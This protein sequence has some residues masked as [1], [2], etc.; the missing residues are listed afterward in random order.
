[1]ELRVRRCH[2]VVADGDSAPQVGIV[3][4]SN[5]HIVP[6]LLNRRVTN[7]PLD[8][9]FRCPEPAVVRLHVAAHVNFTRI[10]WTYINRT[11]SGFDLQIDSASH[12]QRP[13]E[14]AVG[15]GECDG[16]SCHQGREDGCPLRRFTKDVHEFLLLGLKNNR[17]GTEMFVPCPTPGSQPGL[18]INYC[19]MTWSSLF[20]P[21]RTSVFAPFEIPIVIAT[22]RIPSLA[23]GSGTWTDAFRSLSYR[24]E[25]SGICRTSLC[26][27]S[28]I[29]AFAVISAFN[30]PPGLSMET[31]TSNVVTLSF[32]TP[33]GEILVTTPL[34]VLSLKDSTLIRAGCPRYTL[35]MSLSSTFPF[36]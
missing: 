15:V 18:L 26:S 32:S 22:L 35:P 4:M 27:S 14:T 1:M 33:I 19:R 29:S 23:L 11:R 24:M 28:I 7:D 3:N 8:H 6:T 31:R 25:P 21:F 2:Q 9:F 34:N 16:R 20:R 36:T 12:F 30:S 17:K 13:L 5:S 10:S